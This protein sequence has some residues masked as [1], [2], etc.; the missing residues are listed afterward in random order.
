[1]TADTERAFLLIGIK[2]Q[3]QD[4]LRFLWVDDIRKENLSII[5][6]RKP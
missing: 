3:D 2:K 5:K 6:Y 4:F 1:M